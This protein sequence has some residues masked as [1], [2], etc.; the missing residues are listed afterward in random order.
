MAA[1]SGQGWYCSQAERRGDH[2][3][4]PHS[5]AAREGSEKNPERRTDVS[6]TTDREKGYVEDE[7][8]CEHVAANV[9]ET[10]GMARK[11]VSTDGRTHIFP[12]IQLKNSPNGVLGR[13]A[14]VLA[15]AA[16]VLSA[17][18]CT[19]VQSNVLGSGYR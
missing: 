2:S 14:G 9:G 3:E 13:R 5:P 16:D 18:S 10:A 12:A 15:A 4:R 6:Q 17:R 1:P 7:D 11:R 8:F 19:C